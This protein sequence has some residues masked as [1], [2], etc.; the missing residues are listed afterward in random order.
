VEV[1]IVWGRVNAE[2][3]Q[4]RAWQ[5][6]P[7]AARARQGVVRAALTASTGIAATI[8]GRGG[9]GFVSKGS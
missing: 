8:T 2:K 5:G 6:A 3:E 7:A 4:I 9:T 1:V